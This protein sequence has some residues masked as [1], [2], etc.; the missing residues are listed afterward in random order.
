MISIKEIKS[1]DKI[2]LDMIYANLKRGFVE[3]ARYVDNP[4][5]NLCGLIFHEAM[6][7]YSSLYYAKIWNHDMNDVHHIFNTYP[8]LGYR[9]HKITDCN[10]IK[11]A[12]S[13]M[14]AYHYLH[15]L[16]N[17]SGKNVGVCH[18]SL[19]H[20]KLLQSLATHGFNPIFPSKIEIYT[21]NY[22]QQFQL[23]EHC[24]GVIERVLDLPSKASV[25]TKAISK[26][27]YT[28]QS[29]NDSTP[30][31]DCLIIGTP[32]R[33][34]TRVEAANALKHNIPVICVAHGNESGTADHPSWGYDDRSFCTHYLG[35]GSAGD[36]R[37][38]GGVYLNSLYDQKLHYIQSNS[39]FIQNNYTKNL[40]IANFDNDF[41]SAK[42]AYIPTR[43]MGTNRLGPFLSISDNDYT[44]WQIKLLEHLPN[45]FFKAHPKQTEITPMNHN[46]VVHGRL[47]E[48][49]N[50]FDGFITD[51]VLST[52]FANIALTDKPII[53][54]NIGF[55]K[56]TPLAKE[57]IKKRVIWIDVDINNP[58]NI[59]RK[60]ENKSRRICVNN[61]TSQFSLAN[62][63]ES[64]I[65][66]TINTIQ[67]VFSN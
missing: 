7:F 57:V 13:K 58:G 33:F 41:N 21:V 8:Y 47:E 18:P 15:N 67:H 1:T 53:Y 12:S 38:N 44:E 4:Y 45:I 42:I 27:F 20:R 29:K 39:E 37:M 55:G 52:A 9:R 50:D 60:I 51:N 26:S 49:I 32:G 14:K 65:E 34:L 17:K 46:R 11:Y 16:T 10:T 2:I 63:N 19:Q 62:T 5:D 59:I 43:L 23:I 25:F 54:L 61:Y 24:F 28:L 36:I 30:K 6:I 66:T 35:Y 48:C 22:K 64:R 3:C 56:L 31:Y 40:N